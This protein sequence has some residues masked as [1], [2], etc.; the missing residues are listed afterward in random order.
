MATQARKRSKKRSAKKNPSP[1]IPRDPRSAAERYEARKERERQRQATQ[2]AAGRDIAA[3]MPAIADK[4]ARRKC[5]RSLKYFMLEVF[6]DKFKKDFSPDHLTAI[7][8]MESSIIGGL[9]FALSMP[10]GSG[11]TTLIICAVIWAIVTGRR[12]YVAL[13]GPTQSHARKMLRTIKKAF[14]TNPRLLELY[15]EACYPVRRLGGIVNRARGQLY[16]GEHTHIEWTKSHIVLGAIPRSKCSG[17]IIE[18]AG[19]TGSIRGMQFESPSGE[20]LRPDIVVIDDPQTKRSAKS[21]VQVDDRLETIQGDILGLAGPGESIAGFLLCTVIRRGDV[22]D[23]LLSDEEYPDWQGERFQ[24]IYKWPSEA[25]EEL[26]DKYAELRADDLRSGSKGL[27]NATAFYKKH[28]KKMDRGAK[29]GW[30]DRYDKSKGEISAL[31][32]VYNLLLRDEEAFWCE[33]QNEPRDPDEDLD[34]LTVEQL[35]AKHSGYYRGIVPPPA[36]VLTAFVDVQGKCLYWCVVAWRSTDFSGWIVDYGAWPDQ[37][38]IHFQLKNVRRTLA[39]A[40]PRTGLEGRIKAGLIDLVDY[41]V[42]RS[43]KTPAGGAHRLARIGIDAA[44]GPSTRIV[45]EVARTHTSAPLLMPTFGRGIKPNN[46]PIEMWPR[47]EG[48]RRGM[49]L[50][51]RPTSGG[52]RHL[53]SDTNFWKTFVHNRFS[54]ADG[55]KGSLYLPRPKRRQKTEHRMLAEHLRAEIRTHVVGDERRGDVWEEKS[56]KPDNHLFDCV[57][58]CAVFASLEGVQLSEYSKP[59]KKKRRRG[60]CGTLAA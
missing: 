24:L 5:D 26:W 18:V 10:R 7:K 13:I 16:E 42:G 48:E 27:P 57:V 14:E 51:I 59:K 49:K 8:K 3:G 50:I 15:P 1:S 43:W 45:Q 35:L 56:N 39:K 38:S 28:R 6:P 55:D 20:T 60:Y 4:A 47:R 58:H 41:L 12:R 46:A 40:Y 34:L 33:Y 22:A 32:H 19:M 53:L 54:T 31:Q 36:D 17:A 11:K 21:D 9:L 23:Q 29:V 44:W 30:A 25:A 2:S 37:K 52:G